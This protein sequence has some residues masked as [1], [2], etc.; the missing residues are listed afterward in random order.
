MKTLIAIANPEL[1]EL[2]WTKATIEKL[3]G[4][5]EMDFAPFNRPFTSA[6]LADRIGEYDA[7]ITSWGSPA[8]TPEVLARAEK[9]KFIGHGAGSVVSIVNE[10][11]FGTSIAV[12]SANPV[13]ALSTAECAVA[14]ILAG[15]WDMKSYS[16]R[17]P[18][19]AW[20]D[21]SRET[22]LGV[23]G[24]TI[25][26]VGYGEIS[27]Q[28]IRMLKPFGAKVLLYSAHCA[29]EE[30]DA[31][32]AELCG[33]NELF[34]RSDIVSLHNTWTPRTEGMIGTEQLKRLRDGALLVNTA[35]GPIVQE[36]ALLAE[37]R[38]HRIR[39]ALDV[40]DREPLPADHEL[41]ALPNVI[42]LPHIGGFHD[43]LKRSLCDF[44]VDE[45]GRFASG[46]H[47][48]GRITRDRYRRLTPR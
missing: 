46:E 1:R 3:A 25:G 24:R 23:T 15:A 19:G 38:A 20:S 34:E 9:L 37:L 11:V 27:K 35:R 45:L 30:A 4:I 12:T 41:P 40:Y 5:S 48:L 18:R 21:N 33:L 36:E 16:A 28:V 10:D 8:F 13:L 6:D 14:L 29:R 44:V 32:G 39:A 22:V 17:I 7:C 47:L 43:V 42:C 26:L 2:F 31:L